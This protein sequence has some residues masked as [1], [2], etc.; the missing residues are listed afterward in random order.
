MHS[1]DSVYCKTSMKAGARKVGS[2][3][4][5]LV[6]EHSNMLTISMTENELFKHAV[7]SDAYDK[8][9]LIAAKVVLELDEINHSGG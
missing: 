2:L 6:M 4:M 3:I 9:A 5:E 8:C 7:E 1:N